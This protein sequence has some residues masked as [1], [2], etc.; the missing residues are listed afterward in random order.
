MRSLLNWFVLV[1]LICVATR[2]S[3]AAENPAPPIS[4]SGIYPH[5]AM[6]N[7]GGEC[8][9]GAVVPW[10]GK[11]WVITYPPHLVKGSPDK[12]YAISPDMS[13]EIRP[14]SVGGTHANRLIHRESNQLVIGYHF[15]DD[16]GNVRTI[17]PT[18]MIGRM[19][20]TARHLTDP[21][22][23]VYFCDMEG[24]L[25]EVDV[26]TLA[27][28]KL[29]ARV[30][31]GAHGKGG[32][33]GQG[34]LVVTNN[35]E[36]VVNKAEPAAPEIAD[37][38]KEPE[39][40]GALAEWDGK[41]W[42]V[43]ERR[44]F[45]DVTGPG[46]IFGAPDDKAPLWTIGWDKRS[47]ILMLLD[48]GKWQKFRLPKASHT[49]DA[50]HGWYTEWPRIR[51]I[52][53]AKDGKPARLMMDMNG[54]FFDFPQSFSA[55]NTGGI[56]PIASHL[57][58]VPDFG[59][60]NGKVVIA[61]DDCSIMQNPMAGLSQSNLWFGS[62]DELSKW[63]PKTAWGGVWLGD[64]VKA[65]QASDPFLINGFDK[66][67]LHLAHNS[68]ETVQF[69]LEVDQVGNGK[70]VE[71]ATAVVPAGGYSYY[72][73]LPGL[74]AQWLRVVPS[75]DCRAT[76]YFHYSDAGWPAGA[77]SKIFDG[78]ADIGEAK[79]V[80]GLIR[81]AKHNR[82]LQLL[83]IPAAG[84][85][86][87]EYF[88]VDEKLVFHRKG[89]VDP[90]GEGKAGDAPNED[91]ALATEM[92]KLCEIKL[93]FSV[94]A[95]SVI[96]NRDGKRYRLPKGD[97]I[98]DK[99]LAFGRPRAIREVQSERFLMNVHGTFYELPRDK[100]Y[101][102]YLKPVASHRKAIMDFCSWRGLL[103]ISGCK[104]DAPSDGNRFASADGKVSLW[105]G[106][107]DDLWQ[108]G[109]PVGVG[110][111][112]AKTAVKAGEFSDQYL[113]T[114]YASKKLDI[115]IEGAAGPVNVTVEVDVDHT[116]FRQYA[117]FTVEPGKPFS[118]EFPA[119]YSAHWV[120]L[121]TDKDCTATAT[122]TYGK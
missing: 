77:S 54:M 85:A 46:G 26:K 98:F 14:E 108:L 9:I 69:K 36:S 22:N 109:Q 63:G 112:W 64:D 12:L 117:T 44:Q 103:V 72:P 58:Y 10:A 40:A 118:H 83:T 104:A 88:E 100:E 25:Y 29:F 49:Y 92:Q 57:R 55:A 116:R 96:F 122:F 95:A 81:P 24:A 87:P 6:Y 105:F 13:M 15:I 80:A 94:D 8:G 91:A 27:V 34:R 39:A 68:K 101:A 93:D 86:L 35:G 111:P 56:A 74:K 66:R 60:W 78:L 45:L 76:A 120:R 21:A 16:K 89:T 50:K 75:R 59:H 90:T 38:K 3:I 1:L 18:K 43:V 5:L 121:K 20:A 110:G 48:D 62:A 114:G 67:L 28:K 119:A 102:S 37:P 97:P 33:T 53:P 65:G 82:N 41:T 32:Y 19:T 52:E 99:P 2:P 106:K 30:A 73:I 84:G 4:I 23:K 42:R 70:W 7:D 79:P 61:A 113:M 47:V 31:P 71:Y 11:L 107:V 51:E 115:S 17:E